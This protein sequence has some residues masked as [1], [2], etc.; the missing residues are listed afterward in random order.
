VAIVYRKVPDEGHMCLL[1]Y[2]D[3]LP[4]MVHDECMKVLE[5]EVGQQAKEYADALFRH[6][7]PDGNNCLAYIHR[8]GYL[9][10][11]PCIQ[12]I[13]TPTAK[14]ACRLDELNDIIDKLEAGGEA[15]D[16]LADMDSNRGIKGVLKEGRELGMPAE[17]FT[18]GASTNVSTDALS[19]TDLAQQRIDQASKM[20]NEA[21]GLLAEAKRLREEAAELAPVKAKNV[22]T[23]KA[24]KAIA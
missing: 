23:T 10:K 19:D 16:R 2:T 7:M 17:P 1:M 12:V 9:K 6:T 13:V 24:K 18:S 20:E 8:A 21:K 11:V 4:M 3:N 14:S 15:A 5:S 22:R